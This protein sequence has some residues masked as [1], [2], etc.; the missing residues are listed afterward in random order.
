MSWGSSTSYR[1]AATHRF[2]DLCSVV[3]R[4]V[5]HGWQGRSHAPGPSCSS[6]K[7]LPYSARHFTSPEVGDPQHPFG[8][9]HAKII[10]L[11]KANGVLDFDINELGCKSRGLGV[12]LWTVESSPPVF[13]D[14]AGRLAS[15][16]R[17]GA[18][19]GSPPGTAVTARVPAFEHGT[20]TYACAVGHGTGTYACAVP[21]MRDIRRVGSGAE[22]LAVQ[23]LR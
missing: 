10:F 12:L 9:V 4:S 6:H 18:L 11:M 17:Y 19:T 7:A 15:P 8:T 2:S 14:A 23:Q 16:K 1:V 21:R 22:P 20:G 5:R 3:T 13:R